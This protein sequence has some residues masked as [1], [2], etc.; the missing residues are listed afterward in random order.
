MRMKVIHLPAPGR[1]ELLDGIQ[2]WRV[3]GEVECHEEWVVCKPVADQSSPMETNIVP[4]DDISD[5][6]WSLKSEHVK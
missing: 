4:Y 6:L 5:M 1:E 3:W 2:E